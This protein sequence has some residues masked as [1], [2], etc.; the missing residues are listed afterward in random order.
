MKTYK[1][2]FKTSHG[3]VLT[4]E[5][6]DNM[7]AALDKYE[8][9]ARDYWMSSAWVEVRDPDEPW[10][11]RKLKVKLIAVFKREVSDGNIQKSIST[12]L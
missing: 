11:Y 1:P 4:G 3:R 5:T 12:G 10:Y 7:Q 8:E 9:W 6:Y 2:Y